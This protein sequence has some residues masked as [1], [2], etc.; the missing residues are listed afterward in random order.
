MGQ[1]LKFSHKDFF[2]YMFLEPS[3]GPLQIAT[4]ISEGC[5]QKIF[6]RKSD[7]NSQNLSTVKRGY[8]GQI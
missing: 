5:F 3:R 4:M 6:D 1:K 7:K 2:K 8:S